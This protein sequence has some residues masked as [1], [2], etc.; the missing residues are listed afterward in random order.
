MLHMG[1]DVKDFA[2]NKYYAQC[3]SNQWKLAY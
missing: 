1:T 2:V 3:K